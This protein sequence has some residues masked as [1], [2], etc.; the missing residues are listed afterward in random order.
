[1]STNEEIEIKSCGNCFYFKQHY[2]I[3]AASKYCKANCGHCKF[4]F[5]VHKS[6]NTP[7]CEKWVKGEDLTKHYKENAKIKLLQMADIVRQL[8]EIFEDT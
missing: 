8:A 6:P 1:M 5:P 4:R 7:C 2:V 3:S